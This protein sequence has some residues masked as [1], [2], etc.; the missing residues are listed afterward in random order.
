M[1]AFSQFLLEHH[2]VRLTEIFLILPMMFISRVLPVLDHPLNMY[3]TDSNLQQRVDTHCLLYY[4][5]DDIVPGWDLENRSHEILAYCLRGSA[6]NV[7]PLHWNLSGSI[8]SKWTFAELREKNVT[9]EMLLSWS[10]PI[11][12]AEDYQ[13]FLNTSSPNASS[14]EKDEFHNCTSSWFGP[15]CLGYPFRSIRGLAFPIETA[16]EGPVRCSLL[17]TSALYDTQR[18]FGL[19]EYLRSKDRLS[20]WKRR[21]RLLATGDERMFDRGISMSPRSMH[22]NRILP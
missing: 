1:V 12:T 11:D 15:H 7:H 10:A 21:D 6:G 22:T 17:R 14:I 3:V 19:A 8:D 9:S 4:V 5:L 13:M 2:V 18:L 16:R 20:R